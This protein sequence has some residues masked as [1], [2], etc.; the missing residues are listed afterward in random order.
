M[1]A[2]LGIDPAWSEK[3]PSGVALI[4]RDPG[5]PWKFVA[6]AP[7]YGAFIDQAHGGQVREEE[8]PEG[9]APQPDELLKAA[10]LLLDGYRVSVVSVDMPLSKVRITGRRAAD[11]AVSREFGGRGCSTHSPNSTTPGQISRTVSE[12]L[13]ARSY[14]LEVSEVRENVTI[15]VYPHPALLT[16]LK[17]EYRVPYKVGKR[18]LREAGCII[19]EFKAIAEGL[20]KEIKGIPD[21]LPDRSAYQ[22]TKEALKRYEDT[23]DALVCAW[24]GATYL[25]G[26]AKPFGDDTA[27]IWVPLK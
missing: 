14:P 2:V 10:E 17:R 21:C 4:C 9:G 11:N 27:A 16:L 19:A 3:N 23:L 7:S 26:R 5:K 20:S 8:K 12:G 18:P 1:K 15:E 6:A 13:E 25:E 24:V 22:G